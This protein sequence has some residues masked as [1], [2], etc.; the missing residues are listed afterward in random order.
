MVL[1]TNRFTTTL[2]L[3]SGALLLAALVGG[4][5]QRPVVIC[6]HPYIMV[7]S[8]CCLDLNNDS[9]CD[10]DLPV[11]EECPP[12]DCSKCEAQVVERNV[13]VTVTKYVCER[14]GEVVAEPEECS[15]PTTNPF[16]SYEPV[17]T[18]EEGTVIDLFTVRPACRD[19]FPALEAHFK[20]GSVA[21]RIDFQV[22]EDPAGEWRTLYTY[23]AG[24]VFEKYLYAALCPSKCTSN[25]D[26]FL[27]PGKA[28]L[29]RARFDYRGLYGEYQYSNEH[30]IDATESGPYLT[31]PC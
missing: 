1:Q 16:S 9:V 5:T 20:V 28:Y 6:E 21:S 30:V 25:A 14:T 4:C 26:F 10:A 27:E 3:V 23:D 29:F 11:R 12:L 18:N 31:K 22:K 19:S 15:A 7:G 8:E 13:T 24:P 2:I 17:S